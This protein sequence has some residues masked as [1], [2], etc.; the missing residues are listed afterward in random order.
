MEHS[1]ST[2]IGT[3]QRTQ[4]EHEI[5][6]TDRYQV[7]PYSLTRKQDDDFTYT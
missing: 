3:N 5:L 7:S 2:V 6:E 1:A 4:N